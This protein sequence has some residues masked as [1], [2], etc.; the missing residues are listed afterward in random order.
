MKT[1]EKLPGDRYQTALAFAEDLA[2]A[3]RGE[4]VLARGESFSWRKTLVSVHRSCAASLLRHRI[5][6]RWN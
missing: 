1:L 2:R 3:R 5:D 6:Q 4:R